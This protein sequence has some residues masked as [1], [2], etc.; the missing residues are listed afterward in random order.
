MV[1]AAVAGTT[2]F[3]PAASYTTLWDVTV[4]PASSVSRLPGRFRYDA[5]S[6]SDFRRD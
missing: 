5:R 1:S 4:F 2:S 3:R 6:P